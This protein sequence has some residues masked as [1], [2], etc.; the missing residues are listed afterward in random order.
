MTKLL[1]FHLTKEKKTVLQDFLIEKKYTGNWEDWIFDRLKDIIAKTQSDLQNGF[2]N[3]GKAQI[4][5]N[6]E[7]ISKVKIPSI[8]SETPGELCKFSCGEKTYYYLE[9][10]CRIENHLRKTDKADLVSF[11]QFMDTVVNTQVN[12]LYVGSVLDEID[13][14]RNQ[15]KSETSTN[16]AA[17]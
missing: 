5:I 13:A 7:I 4:K 16:K 6:A 9:T 1:P 11:E 3:N 10:A 15:I 12:A 17:K 14:E 2:S 8:K